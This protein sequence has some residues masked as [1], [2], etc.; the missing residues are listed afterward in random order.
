MRERDGGRELLVFR[1]SG[2]EHFLQ[3]PAGRGDPGEAP[4]ECLR[5]ELLEEAGID[6]YRV[7]RELAIAEPG[8]PSARYAHH[9][10]LVEADDLPDTWEHVV[11]RRRRRRRLPVHVHVAADRRAAEPLARG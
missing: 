11:T 1:Q 3:V 2:Y 6:R 4:E 7:I 5:R 9:A 10:F 8:F